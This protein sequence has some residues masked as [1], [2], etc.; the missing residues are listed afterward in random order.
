MRKKYIATMIVASFLTLAGVSLATQDRFAL[1]SPNGIAFSE[2]QG[3]ETWQSV[4]PSQTEDG[5][6]VILGNAVAIDAYK[7]GIPAN[8][9]PFPDGSMI[10]KIE[11]SKHENSA[12]PDPVLIP[13]SLRAV[14]FMKKDSKRFPDT[15]GWGYAQLIIDAASG[16]I[17]PYGSDG[18][19][20]TVCHQCHTLVQ[21]RDFVFTNYA[22]R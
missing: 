8:G 12:S 3:Y 20:V 18:S 21:E 7:K 6:K 10:A 22:G 9:K 4:A 17:Q 1:K 11:W 19:F 15:D 14:G 13:D 2:F 16:A 5:L